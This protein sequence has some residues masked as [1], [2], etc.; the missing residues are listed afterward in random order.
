MLK[1]DSMYEEDIE[2]L[3][4]AE[5]LV[6]QLDDLDNSWAQTAASPL[7]QSAQEDEVRTGNT[8][9]ENEIMPM[10]QV[11]E[12]L[13]PIRIGRVEKA[14]ARRTTPLFEQIEKAPVRRVSPRKTGATTKS[15]ETKEKGKNLKSVMM[16]LSEKNVTVR[17]DICKANIKLYRS[18]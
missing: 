8:G 15:R 9:D 3:K 12:S 14:A 4:S 6:D 7:K 2:N 1:E 10:G 17:V 16:E 5:E 11:E 18:C 13:T